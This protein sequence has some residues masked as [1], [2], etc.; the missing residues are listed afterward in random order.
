MAR[1]PSRFCPM[2]TKTSSM[3]LIFTL[4][5]LTSSATTM[6][7]FS[8][9][10]VCLNVML[11][12]ACST[13]ACLSTGICMAL[14]AITQSFG[15]RAMLSHSRCS[16][17]SRRFMTTAPSTHTGSCDS[18]PTRRYKGSSLSPPG[19]FAGCEAAAVPLDAFDSAAF[20][21][22]G[23]AAEGATFA[24]ATTGAAAC[25]TAAFGAAAAAVLAAAGALPA[26]T[27]TPWR[28]ARSAIC[29]FSARRK[30]LMWSTCRV[31]LLPKASASM[32]KALCLAA[33]LASS[34]A[35]TK[36]RTSAETSSMTPSW[37]GTLPGGSCGVENLFTMGAAGAAAFD[38]VVDIVAA[39]C[40]GRAAGGD[41]LAESPAAAAWATGALATGALATDPA[42][43]GPGATGALATAPLATAA[44]ATAPAGGPARADFFTTGAPPGAGPGVL[45]T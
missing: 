27:R 8:L 24:T 26:D 41:A 25:G 4:W 14:H 2:E 9:S 16:T 29:D 42:T 45:E 17:W 13:S 35:A 30:L 44:L 20:G 21:A 32:T 5:F 7:A 10:V 3:L 23:G 33:L 34:S 36:L 15:L 19:D 11:R 12:K 40:G 6:G 18:S 43:T 39:A 28:C 31:W 38:W 22:A 37:A 1:T